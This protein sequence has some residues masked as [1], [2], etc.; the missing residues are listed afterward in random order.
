MKFRFLILVLA[1]VFFVSG[2]KKNNK[3]N[4]SLNIYNYGD[5]IDPEILE[6]FKKETGMKVSYDTFAVSEDAYTKIKNSGVDYDLLIISDYMIERMI[7]EN[8]ISEID[9]SK[10]NNYRFIDERFKNLEFDPENKYSVPYTWGTVG[11]MFNKKFI[12]KKNLSWNIL[13]DEKYKNQIFM[14]DNPR[15]TIGVAL[16]KLGYSINTRDKKKLDQAKNILVK[17]K[18][19]V[20]AYLSDAIK[21]KMINNE[22]ILAVAYSGDALFCQNQNKNLDYVIPDEGSNLWFDS[23]VVLKNARNKNSAYE[24]INFLC[25]PDIALLNTDYIGHS[26][27][28]KAT[29]EKLPDEIKNNK[30]YWPSDEEFRRCE[31]FHDLGDF[32]KLYNLIWTEILAG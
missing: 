26:T 21:D 22:G 12:N 27:P 2:C 3:D 14:Y 29:L 1:L 23:I 30:I 4:S 9:F 28:N 32:S 10:I 24:F 15:D 13:W 25:R 20:Q 7:K 11:I 31:I 5:Y 8:L 16:K 6:I 17:Q 19:I 18:K